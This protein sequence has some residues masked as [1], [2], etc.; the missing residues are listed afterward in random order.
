L[1][2]KTVKTHIDGLDEEL[3]GG[4]LKGHVVLVSGTP[5]TMKSSSILYMMYQNNIRHG[6][7]CLYLSLEERK[8]SLQ[9]TMDRLGMTG[10][11]PE[12]F[13]IV[14]IARLRMEKEGVEEKKDWFQIIKKFIQRRVESEGVDFIAIDSLTALYTLTELSNPRLQIF[15]FFGF[16]KE[17][18][19]NVFLISEMDM[20][21]QA[22]G[23]YKEDFLADGTFLLH[24][25]EQHDT[26]VQLRMRIVKMRHA[27]HYR[28]QMALMHRNGKL[29]VAPI[30]AD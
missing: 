1:E 27:N 10:Y 12:K 15:H 11:D 19:V 24:Y 4:I 18:G 8:E 7:R 17:L 3:G 6:A 26:S 14:D 25:H 5:G 9:T 23:N 20:D 29:M 13:S 28:G 2:L 30:V 22:Y 16:L 21:S